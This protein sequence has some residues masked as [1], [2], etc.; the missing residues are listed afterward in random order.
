MGAEQLAGPLV[1]GALDLFGGFLS[2]EYQKGLLERQQNFQR[3]LA[4]NSIRYR[5]EDAQRAG[6]HPLYA[7]G[8][9]AM[10][11][12]PMQLDDHV[13]PALGQMGQNLGQAVNRMLDGPARERIALEHKLLE[14]QIGE[15]DAR[16]DLYLSEAARNRQQPAAPMPGLG[17]VPEG[18]VSVGPVEIEGQNPDV[19]GQGYVERKPMEETSAKLGHPDT[20]AGE[21][22]GYQEVMYRGMPMLLP[23]LQGESA[24]EIL[25]EMSMPTFVGLIALNA[26]TYG[27]NW[28]RDFV[29][30]RYMGEGSK[31]YYPTL[32]E[33]ARMG[34]MNTPKMKI[35]KYLEGR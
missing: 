24:E 34:R 2:N 23:V 31:E 15:S 35:F 22:P 1:G 17:I 20:V 5:V 12:F 27:G 21:H 4:Q 33:Q 28:A 16:K 7:L 19:R 29:R 8:A 9:P 26:K 25:S 14:S 18:K 10:T 6:I 30:L 3:E 13:G 32:R 11:S